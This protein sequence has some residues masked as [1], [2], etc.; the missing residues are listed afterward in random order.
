QFETIQP[1]IIICHLC[2]WNANRDAVC[3]GGLVFSV[4]D[5][6]AGQVF[7]SCAGSCPYSCEDLWPQNQCVPLTCSP[8]CSC[9]P[10]AVSQS[11]CVTPHN[12]LE[13]A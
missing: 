5:C 4:S 3:N 2:K 11:V 7:S 10:G 9:P 12:T 13:T 8:G 1:Q 6:P